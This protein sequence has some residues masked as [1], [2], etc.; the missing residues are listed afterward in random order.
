MKNVFLWFHKLSILA[1]QAVNALLLNGNPDETVSARA[2]RSDWEKTEKIINF[3]FWFDP[4]HCSKSHDRDKK[5]ARAVLF[6]D[7]EF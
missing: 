5:F 2:H 7:G 3:I 6:N 1:S 4:D